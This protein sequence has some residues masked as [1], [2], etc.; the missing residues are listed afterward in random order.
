MCYCSYVCGIY[1]Y[2]PF[3]KGIYKYAMWLFSWCKKRNKNVAEKKIALDRTCLPYFSIWDMNILCILH[4]SCWRSTFSC[5]IAFLNLTNVD[6]NWM[7][8]KF[9]CIKLLNFC[10]HIIDPRRRPQSRPVVITIFTQIIRPC[11]PKLQNQAT[12][13]A[14]RV[15]GLAE[16][17][18]DD[19][20]LVL[21]MTVHDWFHL[22]NPGY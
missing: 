16:W 1:G 18:L 6:L 22:W 14:G 3:K 19:S 5:F 17:I 13:T 7:I 21:F 8:F 15:C 12:V 2:Y 20:C 10:G 9:G 4:N 11:V